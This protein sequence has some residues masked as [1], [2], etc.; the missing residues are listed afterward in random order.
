[1]STNKNIKPLKSS[2]SELND[3][4]GGY[5][6]GETTKSFLLY[7]KENGPKTA[8]QLEK[9]TFWGGVRSRVGVLIKQ[10]RIEKV[11]VANP[12]SE[13]HSRSVAVAFKFIDGSDVNHQ[14][15]G[16]PGRRVEETYGERVARERKCKSVAKAIALLNQQGFIVILPNARYPGAARKAEL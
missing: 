14:A 8:K 1:M 11:K 7:L 16:R 6:H 15:R 2:R 9:M 4:L 3:G 12:I 13:H 5:K 10:G